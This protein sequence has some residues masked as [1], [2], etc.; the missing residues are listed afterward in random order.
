[1]SYILVTSSVLLLQSLYLQ[2]FT[3]IGSNV[4]RIYQQSVRGGPQIKLRIFFLKKP[5]PCQQVCY[6]CFILGGEGE[7]KIFEFFFF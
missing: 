5:L 7:Q 4:H 1:M 2:D 6:C 3:E